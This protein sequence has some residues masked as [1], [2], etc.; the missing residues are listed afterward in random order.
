VQRSAPFSVFDANGLDQLQRSV[1][2]SKTAK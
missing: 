2:Y 1:P